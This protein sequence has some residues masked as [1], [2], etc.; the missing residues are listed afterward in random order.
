VPKFQLNA[1]VCSAGSFMTKISS[2]N[3]KGTVRS[4]STYLYAS[5]GLL[6]RH[7]GPKQ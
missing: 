6:A 1:F 5:W 4:Q 2:I 3:S 7:T